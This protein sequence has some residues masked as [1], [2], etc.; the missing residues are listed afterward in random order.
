MIKTII[1]TYRAFDVIKRTLPPMIDENTLV[2]DNSEDEKISNFLNTLNC[3]L[4]INPQNLGF[5]KSVNLG[6]ANDK[7]VTWYI[8]ANPD[9]FVFPDWRQRV[10]SINLTGNLDCGIIGVQLVQGKQAHHAGG[11]KLQK[12][13]DISWTL[14]IDYGNFSAQEFWKL[15]STRYHE[16]KASVNTFDTVEQVD[17]VSFGLVAIRKEVFDTI[18]LLNEDFF[19]YC[20]DTEFCAR[21]KKQGWEIWYNPVVFEHHQGSS[22]KE[23]TPE[24]RKLVK[25]D[26]VLWE[27]FQKHYT[28][29]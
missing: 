24:L 11:L 19:L 7:E 21:A 16:R 20:S 15:Q 29:V 18:G 12:P 1:I 23:M 17:W 8:L 26:F 9:V 14:N 3:D 13:L 6:L 28:E 4:I 25:K 27:Q 10:L 22:V 5:T 2:I